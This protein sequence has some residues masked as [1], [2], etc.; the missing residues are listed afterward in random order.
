MA[1]MKI[2]KED[3]QHMKNAIAFLNPDNIKEHLAFII[4][5]EKAKDINM[6]LRWDTFYAAGLSRFACDTL[7]KYGCNDDHIDTALKAIAKELNFP[8]A[9]NNN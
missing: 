5:E 4:Q 7:Y 1:R 3:Y 8:L 9:D 6:R 2:K